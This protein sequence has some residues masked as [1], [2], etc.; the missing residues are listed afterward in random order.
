M[1]SKPC[2]PAT[3]LWS[4]SCSV[5]TRK[6]PGTLESSRIYTFLEPCRWNSCLH[7]NILGLPAHMDLP[8]LEYNK[9][10]FVVQ[11]TNVRTFCKTIS[12]TER[13]NPVNLTRW[14]NSCCDYAYINEPA[15]ARKHS[16]DR[17]WSKPLSSNLR[18]RSSTPH[19][20]T[21]RLT[22]PWRRLTNKYQGKEKEIHFPTILLI[23]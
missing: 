19:P 20:T 17:C 10:Y 2:I 5:D 12:R 1:F 4:R 8:T 14:V 7:R 11:N 9:N 23:G 18:L 6:T 13:H 16:I 21:V 3:L 15:Y 22:N